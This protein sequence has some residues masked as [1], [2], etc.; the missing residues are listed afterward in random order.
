MVSGSSASLKTSLYISEFLVHILLEPGLK[1]FEHNLA[2]M[3]TSLVAQTIKHLSTMWE[4]WVQSLGREGHLEKEMATGSSILAW[5]IPWAEELGRL[6]FMRSLR[7]GH[8]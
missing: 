4:I 7:V 8:N 5:K 3:W 6:Q 1:D 2:S